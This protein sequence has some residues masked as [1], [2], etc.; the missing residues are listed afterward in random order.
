MTNNVAV[1]LTTNERDELVRGLVLL[2]TKSPE[3]V[4]LLPLL[5]QILLKMA[6]APN[7]PNIT[8]GVH[9]G[10]VQWVLGNPFPIRVCDYDGELA[11]LPNLDEQEQRC[12]IWFEPVDDNWEKAI[13][14][15]HPAK[16]SA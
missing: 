15:K 4:Q 12:R 6:R 5:P 10:Q 16:I 13:W 11:E 14:R 8:I 1:T 9:G 3:I 2:Q 7:W